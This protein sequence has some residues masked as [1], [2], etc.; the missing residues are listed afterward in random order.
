M[1]HAPVLCRF[2]TPRAQRP[3]R[4]TSRLSTCFGCTTCVAP[5]VK[6]AKPPLTHA[7]VDP[8]AAAPAGAKR[9]VISMDTSSTVSETILLSQTRR[10]QA[11]PSCVTLAKGPPSPEA[12]AAFFL[13]LGG[14]TS[15]RRFVVQSTLG[16]WDGWMQTKA[17]DVHPT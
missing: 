3:L 5:T 2:V 17:I 13:G 10:C 6:E 15:C 9:V 12:A 16:Q 11:R 14:A 4:F 8:G 7:Y 1:K